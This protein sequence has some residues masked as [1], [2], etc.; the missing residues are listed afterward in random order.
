MSKFRGRFHY[1]LVDWGEEGNIFM[2]GHEHHTLQEIVSCPWF[3][4][5]R[6]EVMRRLDNKLKDITPSEKAILGSVRKRSR[7]KRKRY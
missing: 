7:Y 5:Q 2:C 4:T 1:V 6:G 3:V